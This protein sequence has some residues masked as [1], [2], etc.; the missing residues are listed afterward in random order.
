[1]T[2]THT[3]YDAMPFPPYA[4]QEYPKHI[5]PDGPAG[6]FVE[7]AD[8]EEEFAILAAAETP[9][10]RRGARARPSG[11]TGDSAALED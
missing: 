10:A 1:M 11:V 7:V 2:K 4:Y 5:H 3:I 9:I 6:A 8:E